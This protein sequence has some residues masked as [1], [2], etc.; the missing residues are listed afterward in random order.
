MA[1]RKRTY[2]ITYT[3][4]AAKFFYKGTHSHPVRRTVLI[5]EDNPEFFVGYELRAGNKVRSLKEAPVHTYRKDRIARYGDYSRLAQHMPVGKTTRS[6][7]L[8]RM[9]LLE[10]VKEGV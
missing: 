3:K 7:T 5:I 8:R 10:Y 1:N 9:D 2:D 6:T 4:P